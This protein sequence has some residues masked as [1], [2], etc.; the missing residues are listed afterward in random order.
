MTS[1]VPNP[2]QDAYVGYGEFDF[3]FRNNDPFENLFLCQHLGDYKRCRVRAVLE[4]AGFVV[5][6]ND[7]NA[8]AIELSL[9]EVGL[10]SDESDNGYASGESEYDT[11]SDMDDDDEAME[12][13]EESE[14]E[15][16]EEEDESED[17]QV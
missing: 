17:T 4:R 10:P 5:E 1:F 3:E 2:N 8:K 7:T 12:E 13:D 9:R 11:Y 6:W 14:S 15:G 16:G